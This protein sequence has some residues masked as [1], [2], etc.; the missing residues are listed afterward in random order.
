MIP[1][2]CRNHHIIRFHRETFHVTCDRPLFH[3]GDCHIAHLGEMDLQ[4]LLEIAGAPPDT[5]RLKE[6][7]QFHAEED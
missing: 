4:R 1:I 5:P 7:V 6:I 2:R 3:G